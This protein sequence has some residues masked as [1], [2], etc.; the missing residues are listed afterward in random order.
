MY[1]IIN[2]QIISERQSQETNGE[3]AARIAAEIASLV[4]PGGISG[5]VVSY[6]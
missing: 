2:N 5:V 3:E 1:S 4:D 6:S